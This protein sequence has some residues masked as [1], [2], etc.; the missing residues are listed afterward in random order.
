[1]GKYILIGIPNSGKT[2]I[3]KRAAEKL[4]MPY[5][6]SKTV[7]MDRL[8]R[9]GR[10]PRGFFSVMDGV[11][12]EHINVL[13]DFEE[14][15]ESAIIEIWPECVMNP[16]EVLAMEKIGTIIL[17]NRD[18]EAAIASDEKKDKKVIM[19]NV[20][21]GKAVNFAAQCIPLYVKECGAHLEAAADL[22]IDNDGSI[23]DAVEKLIA[24]INEQEQEQN[25][26]YL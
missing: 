21:T 15:E 1:M 18:V 7:A 25:E 3:G 23:D 12:D 26:N 8:T 4:G 17:I 13:R 10:R 9:E 24:I 14:Q 20:D 2:A 5:Y 19:V 6:D 22:T 11:L 16:D